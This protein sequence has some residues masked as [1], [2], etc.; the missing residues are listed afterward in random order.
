[1][2]INSDLQKIVVER[3]RRLPNHLQISIGNNSYTS[4]ELV[5]SV[6]EGTTLGQQ[7]MGIQ[8]DYLKD[9]ASG[10]IYLDE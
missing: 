8:L 7:I 4:Q 5:S 3:L 2:T 6:R 9:L 10:K 1:M